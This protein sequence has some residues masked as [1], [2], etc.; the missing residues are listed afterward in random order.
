MNAAS[1]TTLAVGLALAGLAVAGPSSADVTF[2]EHEGFQGRSFSTDRRVP[3]FVRR[4]FNDLASSAI[5]SGQRWEVCN[6]TDFGGRCVVLRPGQYPSMGAMGLNDRVSSAREVSPQARVE[7]ERYAPPPVVERDYRRRGGERLYQ[8]EVVSVRAVVATPER[9]CWVER[10]ELQ[11]E[12]RN[13][14]VQGALIGA[15]IGGILGHQVG[16]GSGRDLATVGGVAAGAVVGSQVGRDRGSQPVYG[17]NVERCSTTPSQASPEYW[18]VV[19]E[20]RGKQHQVQMTSP[21]GATVT[22]NRAG[23][24]RA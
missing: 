20:F 5:V 16:G 1:R 12:Q 7:D 17:P 2:Y 19:Y 11:P 9:R 15:V 13:A 21:P 22:V 18:D 23:E 14:N 4:G 8:A 24:P 10:G 6:D 3:D